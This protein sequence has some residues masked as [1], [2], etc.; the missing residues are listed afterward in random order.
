MSTTN[1]EL[2]IKLGYDEAIELLDRAV[3][4]K[5]ADYI[6]EHRADEASEDA[7]LYFYDGKPSCIVGHVLA[8]KGLTGE[9]AELLDFEGTGIFYLQ[10][11]GYLD[12][13]ER[14]LKTLARA[15]QDQDHGNSWGVAVQHAKDGY[16]FD[17]L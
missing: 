14:T 4:E 2:P 16:K 8:Y 6:Y 9:Q 10:G 17:E 11:N 3:K 5:G 1:I 15:Q 12:V 7:C 13:D